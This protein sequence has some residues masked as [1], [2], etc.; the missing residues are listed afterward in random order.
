MSKARIRRVRVERDQ[1]TAEAADLREQ[2]G[3]ALNDLQAVRDVVGWWEPGKD[4]PTGK[5]DELWD[6]VRPQWSSV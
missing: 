6:I 1:A 3:V 2:L 5:R 4:D